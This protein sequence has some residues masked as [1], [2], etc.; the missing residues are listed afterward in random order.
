MNDNQQLCSCMLS[1][2]N[3]N[4]KFINIQT[5]VLVSGSSA[6]SPPTTSIAVVTYDNAKSSRTLSSVERSAAVPD[7]ARKKQTAII[8]MKL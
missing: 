6:S 1:H 2:L 7:H 3:V 5:H 8:V 4:S